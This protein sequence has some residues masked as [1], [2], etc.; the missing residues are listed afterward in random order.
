MRTKQV[1]KTEHQQ[2]SLEYITID[3]GTMLTT[4]AST[5]NPNPDPDLIEVYPDENPTPD[6]TPD[7]D[8]YHG[9][10]PSLSPSPTPSLGAFPD[11]LSPTLL[12]IIF[13]ITLPTL[14]LYRDFT[15]LIWLFS[16]PKYLTSAIYL[17]A[18]VFLNFLFTCWAWWRLE[19]RKWKRWTWL[20]LLLQV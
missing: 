14:D 10:F 12:L 18:G 13:S 20:L 15:M 6:H 7:P 8:N 5:E 2:Y 3:V 1:Q 17:S 9:P 19:P 11:Y 4:I 16:H